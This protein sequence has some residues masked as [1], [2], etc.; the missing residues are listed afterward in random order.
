ML[1][2]D[3]AGFHIL[4]ILSETDGDFNSKEGLVIVDYLQNNFPLGGNFDDEI[5]VL[6]TLKKEEYQFHLRRAAEAFYR[7]STP[8]ERIDF[9]K[10]A[11]KLIKADEVVAR[12]EN[13]M[14]S[15]LFEWWDV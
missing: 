8:K 15:R 1:N 4:S 9:L 11:L 13:A 2:K 5:E 14:I 7:E 12:E 10:F 6:S 3:I